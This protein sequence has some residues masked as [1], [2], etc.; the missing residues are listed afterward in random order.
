MCHLCGQKEIYMESV[1]KSERIDIR[2]SLE[3]K[4]IIERAAAMNNR[5][6]SSYILS[7]VLKQAKDDMKKFDIELL[8]CDEMA[9]FI[10][11][12]ENPPM[13]SKE[14]IDLFR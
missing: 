14:L 13:P 8:D 6:V 3:E 1:G 10:D 5:S 4:A 9:I 11:A 12:L 7:I 2:L